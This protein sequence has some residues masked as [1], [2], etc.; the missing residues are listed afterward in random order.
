MVARIGGD[1]F[2]A[3]VEDITTE[4]QAGDILDRLSNGLSEPSELG[5]EE[6]HP[7]ASVGMAFFPRDGESPEA[8]L[9][10]ADAAMYR[11]KE[12]FHFAERRVVVCAADRL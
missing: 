5:P 2:V 3:I 10:A 9:K 6:F 11:M 1:E 8:L 4:F 12:M 7:S